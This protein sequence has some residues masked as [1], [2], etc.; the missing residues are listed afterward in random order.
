MSSA[1]N[2]HVPVEGFDVWWNADQPNEIHLVTNSPNFT[3]ADGKRPGLRV[4]FSCNPKSANY[5]PANFNR[6]ARLLAAKGHPAP[7][8]VEEHGR[9]LSGRPKLISGWEKAARRGRQRRGGP[10]PCPGEGLTTE[11]PDRRRGGVAVHAV[12]RDVSAHFG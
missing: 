5:S 8:I 9:R 2:P 7:A 4:S 3:D 11:H 6:C 1:E 10:W 12:V